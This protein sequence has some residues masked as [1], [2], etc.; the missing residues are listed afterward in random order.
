L[1]KANLSEPDI[2]SSELGLIPTDL[3]IAATRLQIA[4]L[5][6]ELIAALDN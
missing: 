1:A 2:V 4:I 5:F 3:A 6:M